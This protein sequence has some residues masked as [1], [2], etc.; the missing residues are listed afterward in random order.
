MRSIR[1]RLLAGLLALVAV[2]ALVVGS[3]TYHRILDE[4][5]NLFD[6]QLEQMAIS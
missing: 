5:S 4:T 3:I 2:M 6:Y 1:A